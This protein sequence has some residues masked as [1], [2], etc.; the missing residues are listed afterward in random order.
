MKK[1]LS[2]IIIFFILFLYFPCPLYAKENKG[3]AL[4]TDEEIRDIQ[5]RIY[6]T[7]D[8]EMIMNAI[9][10][11]LENQDYKVLFYDK[12]L[13]YITGDKNISIKDINKWLI[14]GYLAKAGFDVF[15]AIITYGLKS[16]SVAGDLW[17]IKIEFNDKILNLK[18]A[19]NVY[20]KGNQTIVRVNMINYMTG[21][22]DGMF[23][24]KHNRLKTI[25]LKDETAYDIFFHRL[26]KELY[27]DK[28]TEMI[29]I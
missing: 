29:D 18:T 9:I 17:L 12:D 19:V 21:K 1:L 10:E 24:G 23:I 7:N 5:T 8:T 27:K 2:G 13:L 26:N 15:Q 11:V 16:Y 4:L 20:P 6:D 3:K 25:H 14:L 22:R 28:K